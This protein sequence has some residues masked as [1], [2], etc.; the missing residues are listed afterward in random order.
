MIS[1]HLE[2]FFNDMYSSLLTSLKPQSYLRRV[3]EAKEAIQALSE[4]SPPSAVILSDEVPT[5]KENNAV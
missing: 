3:E 1:I 4:Q 2:S 5:L